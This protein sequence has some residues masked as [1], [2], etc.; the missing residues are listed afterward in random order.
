MD[1]CM[2]FWP[3]WE[4]DCKTR[5]ITDRDF[6]RSRDQLDVATVGGVGNIEAGSDHAE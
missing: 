6:F 5:C 2:G 4:K 3:K 1:I